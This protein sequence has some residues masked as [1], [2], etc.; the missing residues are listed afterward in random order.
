MA[1]SYAK[2]A[3][4]RGLDLSLEQGLRLEANLADCFLT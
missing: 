1:V 2:Q 4:T 3:I